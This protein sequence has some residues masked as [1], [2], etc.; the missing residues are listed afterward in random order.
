MQLPPGLLDFANV[1][2]DSFFIIDRDHNIVEFNRAFHSMLPRTV[3]RKLTGKKCYD[4]LHLDICQ[5]NCIAKGCWQS[6]RHLRLDEIS[7][8]FDPEGEAQRL[9]LSAIPLRD[10]QGEFIGALEIQRN[11]TDQ[12]IVQAKYQA[13]IEASTK[14]QQKLEEDLQLRTKR[15]LE[16]SRQFYSAQKALLKSKTDLFG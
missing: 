15:L 11:V 12:A 7:G 4:V 9:I 8:R 10:E 13:Q 3:A 1:I 5:D 14:V 6:G 2:I 16:V